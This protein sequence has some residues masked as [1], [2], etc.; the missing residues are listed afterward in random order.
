MLISIIG[1]FPIHQ[2]VKIMLSNE[3]TMVQQISN[4]QRICIPPTKS[5]IGNIHDRAEREETD[6]HYI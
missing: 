5:H 4:R 2:D 6:M 1:N 3:G